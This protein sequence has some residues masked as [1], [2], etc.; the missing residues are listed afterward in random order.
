MTRQPVIASSIGLGEPQFKISEISG[1]RLDPG[2]RSNPLRGAG[3][4]VVKWFDAGY[5][6]CSKEESRPAF[7]T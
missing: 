7:S 5:H 2:D 4:L 1:L 6:N 3:T